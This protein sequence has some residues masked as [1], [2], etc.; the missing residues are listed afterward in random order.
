MLLT[1]LEV[2]Q[3]NDRDVLA[4]TWVEGFGG[5]SKIAYVMTDNSW[6]ADEPEYIIVAGVTN[7]VMSSYGEEISLVYD[8]INVYGPMTRYGIIDVENNDF[9]LSNLIAEGFTSVL[10]NYRRRIN[11]S[12]FI[13]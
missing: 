10:R 4:A 5:E 7:L 2:Y 3:K 9:A 13:K 8:E 1:Q 6:S 11:N 12:S